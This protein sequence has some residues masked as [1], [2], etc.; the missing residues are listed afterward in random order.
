ML[1]SI[2]II[3]NILV[4]VWR[5]TQ[6]RDQRSSPISILIIMLAVSD[7]FY[8]VHLIL[9]ESLVLDVNLNQTKHLSP[10]SA[11]NMCMTSALLSWFTCLTA[12]WATF[13]IALYSFQAIS[14]FCSRCCCSLVHKRSLVITII[15]QV[16]INVV[17]I[18]VYITVLLN[19][20]FHGIDKLFDLQ[21]QDY[22]KN[23][24]NDVSS[25]WTEV[26]LNSRRERI[27]QIFGR[28]AWAQSNGFSYCHN[29][30][31]FTHNNHTKI[32]DESDCYALDKTF[33]LDST[34]A[35]LLIGSIVPFLG[36]VLTLTCAIL[37][38]CFWITLRARAAN[39]TGRSDMHKLRWRLSVIVLLNTLC[40]IPV[41]IIHWISFPEIISEGNYEWNNN[42]TAATVLLISISPAVNPLIYTFTGKNFLHSIR[43]FCRGM[44]CYIS[45]RRSSSNY[46][47]YHTRGVERCSCIPCV[48]CI[49]HDEENDPDYC[50]TQDTSV[51]NSDQS[52]LLPS[53]NESSETD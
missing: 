29:D 46:H 30:T 32:F 33:A 24:N 34:S 11:R 35:A 25:N 5:L 12:Q 6:K 51:W 45:V 27:A 13:N 42:I 41:A 53:T 8:C 22:D 17:M 49:Q 18:V 15:C 20:Y 3:G 4:V 52:R 44:K 14:E 39:L 43:K 10:I 26:T 47:D 23:T 1:L 19:Y 40:W 16:L 37:Y 31:L 9:L 48:R 36:T 7:F 28:C 38:I 2:G 21:L 50:N